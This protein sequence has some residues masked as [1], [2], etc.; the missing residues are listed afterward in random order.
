MNCVKLSPLQRQ[1][2]AQSLRHHRGENAFEYHDFIQLRS[3][4]NAMYFI[5]NFKLKF[6]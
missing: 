2:D 1:I 3:I 5:N 6:R 4:S